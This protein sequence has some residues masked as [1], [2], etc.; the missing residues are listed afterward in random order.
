MNEQNVMIKP[1]IELGPLVVTNTVVTTWVIMGIPT[2]L[3]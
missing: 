1:F 2:I 3:V